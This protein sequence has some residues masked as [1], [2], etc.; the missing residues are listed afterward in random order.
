H[1]D[2]G[3]G[4]GQQ[5]VDEPPR[6]P[7]RGCGLC[8]REGAGVAHWRGRFF[9]RMIKMA[10][11]DDVEPK[12]LQRH[13]RRV[14]TSRLGAA[15]MRT[16]VILA[17]FGLLVNGLAW[18]GLSREAAD[19]AGDIRLLNASYDPTR[20]L[21]RSLN[22]AFRPVYEANTGRRLTIRQSHGG[23]TAQA[24]AVIDGLAADVVSLAMW[25]DTDAIHARGLIADG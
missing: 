2:D 24:R 23:S 22:D 4:H 12:S 25:S 18:F 11:I 16:T 14:G 21:W 7:G 13:H 1:A 5:G 8:R 17:G 3:D 6:G 10:T 20:E 9:T 19:D 15:A